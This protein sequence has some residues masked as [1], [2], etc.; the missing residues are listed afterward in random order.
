MASRKRKPRIGRN[1]SLPRLNRH[2]RLI[3]SR[4]D[5][6]FHYAGVFEGNA[7]GRSILS[8]SLRNGRSGSRQNSTVRSQFRERSRARRTNRPRAFGSLMSDIVGSE[9][10]GGTGD[11]R[12]FRRCAGSG[13]R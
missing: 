8:G 10:R 4:D 7:A 13:L 2:R 12:H 6:C 3:S 5:R 9:M 11:G 1:V